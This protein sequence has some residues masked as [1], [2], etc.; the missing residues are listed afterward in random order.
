MLSNKLTFS[1]VLVL[2]LAFAFVAMPV[3]AQTVTSVDLDADDPH[4]PMKDMFRV[5]SR[6]DAA[7][8]DNGLTASETEADIPDLEDLLR[9]GG[10]IEL[11]LIVGDGATFTISP[12]DT[13]AGPTNAE[14]LA[15]AY[16][17]LITEV[18]WGLNNSNTANPGNSQWIELYN[19]GVDTAVKTADELA[20]RFHRNARGDGIGE[21]FTVGDETYVVVDQLSTITRFGA[22]WAPKGNSGNTAVI[23]ATSTPITDIVSMYRKI[24]LDLGGEKYKAKGDA[25]INGVTTGLDGLGD[26]TE[27]GSWEASTGR[28]GL[29]GRFIGSAGAHHRVTG[30]LFASFAKAPDSFESTGVI[31]NEVRNDTSEANLDW[32]ELFYNTDS[33][34]ATSQNVENW[35]LS[36]VT[37]TLISGKDATVPTKANFT[38]ADKSLAVLPKYKM[39]PG[40]YLVIYNRHPGRSVTLAGGVNLQDV[41]DKKHVHKGASHMYVIAEDLDLPSDKQFLILLRTRNHNDDVGKPTNIK[42]YA[43]NGFF[44]RMEKNEFETDAWPFV[45]WTTPGDVAGFGDASF[46]SR[47][48]SY[49]RKAEL[50]SLG[51]YWAKSRDHRVHKDDWQGFEFIGTGYDRGRDKVVD[52]RTS[53]GTPGYPNIAVNVKEDDRDTAAGTDDYVF[54]GKVSIS[55]IM[56]DAGPRWNLVQWI[57]LYNSSPTETIK[58]DGWEMEIRNEDSDIE[59]YVDASFE[60]DAGTMI[61]PNQTLLLISSTGTNDVPPNYIYNLAQNER[62]ELGLQT[63]GRRLL[64]NRGFHIELRAKVNVGGEEKM[65]MEDRVGNVTVDG[66]ARKHM[67]DLLMGDEE[68]D[69]RQSI[70]RKYGSSGI[71]GT[72]DEPSDGLMESSWALSDLSGASLTFYGHRDDVST[73][74]FR[75]GGPLP[76]TLS[77][78]RPV[79]NQTTGHV[80]IT[81]ITQSELNN[82]GFNILRSETKT[83]EFKVINVK[84]IIAGH[85]TT[86]EK[87]VYT[88]TDTTAKPNVVYYYQIEDVSINGQRTTLTTT[89][90]RGQVGAAGKL[91]TRWGEL[92]SSGK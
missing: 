55:E 41:L 6:V 57:E 28:V 52:Q 51:E 92:K 40:E 67:W 47:N 2:M 80:D 11:G 19:N 8:A 78:F 27:P 74:G 18:M 53:P 26:G 7:A 49:G 35:E 25:K 30:G 21:T 43:G 66:A 15:A 81:W 69:G 58:L 20:L 4:R 12:A 37:R 16:K 91:T 79:R 14:A 76:V 38:Y 83:G 24:N 13:D 36:I 61:P 17:Y 31:I 84:G 9:A 70:V 39:K 64:S 89:H 46:A 32:I 88:F 65:M 75:L 1:L 56:Y 72:P 68:I 86:S 10:T 45:G 48:M 23:P 50:N 54:S 42:D 33:A 87:H 85:G 59:S 90:L 44:K 63:R 29:G 34:T 82:A 3:M 77:K 62:K 22:I 60:F 5:F 71:D 73:P